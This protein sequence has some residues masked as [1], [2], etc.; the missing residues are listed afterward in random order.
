MFPVYRVIGAKLSIAASDNPDAIRDFRQRRATRG[1]DDGHRPAQ[2]LSPTRA[3][4]ISSKSRATRAFRFVSCPRSG[5]NATPKAD[6]I[7]CLKPMKLNSDKLRFG[8]VKFIVD[9]S[10]QGFT[11]R[12]RWPGYR[13]RQAQW[14]MADSAG[15]VRRDVP[16]VPSRRPATAHPHEWRRSHR[17]RARCNREDPEPAS[18]TAI[19]GTRCST[20]RWPTQATRTRRAAR[21]V[22][23]LLLESHLLLG[24]RALHAD[25][26]RRPREPHERRQASARRTRHHV[27]SAFGCADHAAQSAFHRVVRGATSDRIGTRAG[28]SGTPERRRTRCARSRSARPTRSAWTMSSAASKWASSRTSPCCDEDPDEVPRRTPGTVCACGAPIL[29]GR[30]YQAPA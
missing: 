1:R 11:A 14:L 22:R 2:R 7:A 5:R 29:G 15:A 28:R 12:L 21:H 18:A 23:E 13:E 4:A 16:A 3:C 26:G 17:T 19:I 24:R 10:I 6:R 9:G 30:A 25:D 20:A 27:R 8:P